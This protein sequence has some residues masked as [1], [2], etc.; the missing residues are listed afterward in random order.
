ML[1]LGIGQSFSGGSDLSQLNYFDLVSS[2]YFSK[3]FGSFAHIRRAVCAEIE[4][5]IEV[6]GNRLHSSSTETMLFFDY[7]SCPYIDAAKRQGT[8]QKTCKSYGINV[9]PNTAIAQANMVG[10]RLHFVTWAG[11]SQ[12]RSLL[13]RREL[14]PAYDS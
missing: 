6:L 5:R 14:Q 9:N 10:E 4:K 12:L 11:S 8:F 7:V 1:E 3:G 2:L 13:E